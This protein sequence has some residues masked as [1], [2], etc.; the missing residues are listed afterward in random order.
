MRMMYVRTDRECREKIAV[1]EPDHR[2]LWKSDFILESCDILTCDGF[3]ALNQRETNAVAFFTRD[4]VRFH[5]SQSI[6][7]ETFKPRG[8]DSVKLLHGLIDF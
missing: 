6:A 7:H 1:K 4:G 8:R 3:R 5:Q 2:G